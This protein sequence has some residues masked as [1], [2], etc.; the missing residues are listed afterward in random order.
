MDLSLLSDADILEIHN[1]V[2]MHWSRLHWAFFDEDSCVDDEFDPVSVFV[3]SRSMRVRYHK[4]SF[5]MKLDRTSLPLKQVDKAAFIAYFDACL[6]KLV[7][8]IADELV[9]LGAKRSRLS[10]KRWEFEDPRDAWLP[11]ETIAFTSDF[12]RVGRILL[13]E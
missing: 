2:R 4:L 1:H 13:D 8:R 7:E 12:V 10:L 9:R 5:E 6:R 3:K 11:A